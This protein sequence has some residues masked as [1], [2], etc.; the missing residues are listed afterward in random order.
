[1]FSTE[2]PSQISKLKCG[3]VFHFE[4]VETW[5]K[6]CKKNEC[7]VCRSEAVWLDCNGES[8]IIT[9]ACCEDVI[10]YKPDLRICKSKLGC[11]VRMVVDS[12]LSHAECGLNDHR[13]DAPPFSGWKD[14][15]I[16][17]FLWHSLEK[18]YLVGSQFRNWPTWALT[19]TFAKMM[20]YL[21]THCAEGWFEIIW[22]PI[23]IQNIEQF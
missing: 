3:H 15:Q 13:K 9:K 5:L 2:T 17:L 4:C 12:I 6:N 22:E 11:V 8:I 1:M 7:P 23:L 19:S 20:S 18:H 14:D 16:H 21:L 10:I